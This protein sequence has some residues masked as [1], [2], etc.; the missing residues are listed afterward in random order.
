[1][2][3]KAKLKFGS[4]ICKMMKLFCAPRSR[5]SLMP[6]TQSVKPFSHILKSFLK[7]FF[8]FEKQLGS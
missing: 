2:Y 5:S 7:R 4:F 6:P 3:K 1:M 8:K